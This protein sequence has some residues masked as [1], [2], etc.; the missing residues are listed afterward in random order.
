MPHHA[1]IRW[2]GG[3]GEYPL[4]LEP[5]KPGTYAE[6]SGANLPLLRD[7]AIEPGGAAATSAALHPDTAAALG[8]GRGDLV[9]LVSPA[10]RVE[11]PVS[12]HPGVR[13]GSVRVARGGGHTAFGRFARG[14]GAN[15]MELVAPG[16]DPLGGFPA[17]VGTRVRVER[18][19][20]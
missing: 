12:V 5:W 9:A 16:F 10:G 17:L 19:A 14:R 3:A 2:A 7:L 18:I 13:P 15:V 6:G 11:L 4:L 8:V 20:S 1:E